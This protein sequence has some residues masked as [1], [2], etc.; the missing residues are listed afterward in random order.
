[1]T[2]A[3]DSDEELARRAAAGNRA[4][5]GALVRRHKEAI[6][7]FVRRYIGQR[8]DALD[9]V[10]ETFLAAWLAIGR[11]DYKRPFLPW[12]RTIG[13]NKCRDFGRRQKVRRLLLIAKAAEPEA[14]HFMPLDQT[15]DGGEA[16][17]LLRLDAAIAALPAFYKEA[18]LLTA[19]SG[20]SHLEAA[21]ILKTTSKAVEM[22]VRRARRKL[23]E[24]MQS[25][26]AE[27]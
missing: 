22:R 3:A 8:D 15:T 26:E 17:R 9:V 1:V 19:V 4:A 7:A 10:Q 21:S 24:S 6:F 12:L 2:D 18:F 14:D 5:F 25:H 11:Y 16:A 23:A 20:L 13:L 27:G